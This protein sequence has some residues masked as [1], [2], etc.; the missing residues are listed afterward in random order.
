M[1]I[2]KG[3]AGAPGIVSAKVLYFEK[4]K[5]ENNNLTI[6]EVQQAALKRV[7]ALREKKRN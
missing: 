6:E 2:F 3:I 7:R 4:K 5:K 1:K